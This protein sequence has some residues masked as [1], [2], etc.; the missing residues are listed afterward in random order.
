[1]TAPTV[2][3]QCLTEVWG[4]QHQIASCMRTIRQKL[5]PDA[6]NLISYLCA[7]IFMSDS[8]RIRPKDNSEKEPSNGERIDHWGLAFCPEQKTFFFC[9]IVTRPPRIARATSQPRR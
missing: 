6:R 2:V 8:G 7:A 9:K 1:M 3:N 5:M 4:H